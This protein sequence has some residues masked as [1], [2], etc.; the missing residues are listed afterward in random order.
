MPRFRQQEKADLRDVCPCG[1]MNQVILGVRIEGIVAREA[2]KA[3]VNL[4]EVPWILKGDLVKTNLGL[5][6]NGMD[7]C[8]NHPGQRR[9]ALGVDQL[10]ALD[11]EVRLT[12]DSDGGTPQLPAVGVFAEVQG[13]S[14]QANDDYGVVLI[15]K[16]KILAI[17]I[18]FARQL[19]DFP[20]KKPVKSTTCFVGLVWR[21]ECN[22]GKGGL[23]VSQ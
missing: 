3:L 19:F 23:K 12:A 20:V 11:D 7:V 21:R 17:P 1:D 2:G 4:F 13:R 18:G 15:H 6:R 9:V 14:E 8:L 10:E 16:S 22:I 5:R